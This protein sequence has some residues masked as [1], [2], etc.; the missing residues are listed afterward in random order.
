MQNKSATQLLRKT[1]NFEQHTPK[2]SHA[3]QPH[4]NR[5]LTQPNSH[6]H[7][8]KI[9]NSIKQMQSKIEGVENMM[10]KKFTN[11]SSSLRITC[12]DSNAS[13]TGTC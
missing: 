4:P 11:L 7:P 13:Q 12:E 3:A 8:D 6:P 10:K 1:C 2:H 5:L 9:A